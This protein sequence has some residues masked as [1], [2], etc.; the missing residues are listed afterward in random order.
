MRLFAFFASTFVDILSGK[1]IHLILK[2][3][4]AYAFNRFIQFEICI[5]LNEKIP[6]QKLNIFLQVQSEASVFKPIAANKFS[7]IRRKA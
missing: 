4:F 3:F 6:I 1:N 7:S 5:Q 2:N